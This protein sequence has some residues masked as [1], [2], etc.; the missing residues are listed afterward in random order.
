MGVITPLQAKLKAKAQCKPVF[1]SILVPK[2]S[3]W[4]SCNLALLKEHN[5][6]QKEQHDKK[7][8]YGL[9]LLVFT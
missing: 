7:L 8:F 2:N 9:P 5:V 6:P 4:N 3:I 1:C